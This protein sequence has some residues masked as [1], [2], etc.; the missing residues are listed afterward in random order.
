MGGK[1]QEGS[2]ERSRTVGGI[3]NINKQ[4]D[5]IL[6]GKF[7]HCRPGGRVETTV[8]EFILHL[9]CIIASFYEGLSVSP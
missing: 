7:N 8:S 6:K 2:K 3:G 1:K 9:R 5:C 4:S